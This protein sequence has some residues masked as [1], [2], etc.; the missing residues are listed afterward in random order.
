[1]S[2]TQPPSLVSLKHVLRFRYRCYKRLTVEI[3]DDVGGCFHL[4]TKPAIVRTRSHV[5]REQAVF[6]PNQCPAVRFMLED[7]NGSRKLSSGAQCIDQSRFIYDFT[8]CR[9]DQDRVGF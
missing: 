5:T 4:H 9:V 3:A 6:K 8:A 7:I 2:T 1:M